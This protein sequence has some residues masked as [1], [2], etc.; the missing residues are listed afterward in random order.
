MCH[1]HVLSSG[2]LHCGKEDEALTLDAGSAL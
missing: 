1:E 2:V